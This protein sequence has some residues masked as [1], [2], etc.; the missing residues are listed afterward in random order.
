MIA[1]IA[2]A[3]AVVVAMLAVGGATTTVGDW[4]AGLDKPRWTP[5]NWLF[6]P[7]W[8]VILALAGWAGVLAWSHAASQAGRLLVVAL[9]GVN[10]VLHLLWSPLFFNCRRPDWALVEVGA[11]WLSVLALMVGLGAFSALIPVLLA[12]YLV[13]VAFAAG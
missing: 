3:A 9:F 13:W 2:T 7:A 8:T 12:P 5:P 10:A 11:L 1:T 4:Y 6:A